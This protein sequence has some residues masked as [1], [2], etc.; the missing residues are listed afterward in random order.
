MRRLRDLFLLL[1]TP[2]VATAQSPEATRETSRPPIDLA[3]PARTEVATF[4]LG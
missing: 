3:T 1:T 4:A 2:L